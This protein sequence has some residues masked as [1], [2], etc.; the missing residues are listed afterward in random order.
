MT[1]SLEGIIEQQAIA[2]LDNFGSTLDSLLK[3]HKETGNE[4]ALLCYQRLVARYQQQTFSGTPASENNSQDVA[5]E[6][7][8][9]GAPASDNNMAQGSTKPTTKRGRPK[10]SGETIIKTFIYKANNQKETNQRLQMFYGALVQ[11]GWISQDTEQHDFIDI[12]SGKESSVRV[13][14]MDDVN[15]LSELFRQL[16]VRKKYV[17]LP[18]GVSIWVMVNAHFWDHQGNKEFG[19]KRLRMTHTPKD[20]MAYIDWLVRLLEPYQDLEE[21]RAE[22]MTQQ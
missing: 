14:W 2:A 10:K 16:V 7:R 21:L 22:M 11:I 6:A 15:L 9:F 18:I 8:Y 17:H 1:A 20:K 13:K 3:L 4:N 19:N 12:F 5:G